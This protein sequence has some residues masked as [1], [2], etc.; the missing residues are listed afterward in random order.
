MSDPQNSPHDFNKGFTDSAESRMPWNR[1]NQDMQMG[2]R[3]AGHDPSDSNQPAPKGGDVWSGLIGLLGLAGFVV[4]FLL[5]ANFLDAG[6]IGV[7][8]MVGCAVLG[9]IVGAAPIM[10][11]QS[12][13][14]AIY[15][16][17]L[18]RRQG[19]D[20][21][22]QSLI[23]FWESRFGA[24]PAPELVDRIEDNGSAWIMDARGNFILQ[25]K[26]GGKLFVGHEKDN[27]GEMRQTVRKAGRGGFDEHDARNMM[28]VHRSLGRRSIRVYN[29]SKK[30]KRLM[31]AAAKLTD[32]DV[33]DYQPD[34]RA[35]QLLHDMRSAAGAA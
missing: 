19:K 9:F 20:N 32:I 31:W 10:L 2:R 14:R 16:K 33:E 18:W 13:M 21:T 12:G 5:G 6:W 23:Q 30:T 24:P 15:E 26:N 11:L 35:L 17:I 29:G 3:A 22:A 8:I 7:L 27:N 4:G 28:Q 34:R 25:M 1:L